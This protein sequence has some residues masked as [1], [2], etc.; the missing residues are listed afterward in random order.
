MEVVIHDLAGN[1]LT[2]K[3]LEQVKLGKDF[4]D[5]L[6]SICQRINYDAGF[7]EGLPTDLNENLIA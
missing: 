7:R 5:L 4:Y 6:T 3:D 2:D 1:E